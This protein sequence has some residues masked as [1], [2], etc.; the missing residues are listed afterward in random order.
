MERDTTT[1]NNITCSVP[2]DSDRNVRFRIETIQQT[3]SRIYG[4][5]FHHFH[6]VRL[7]FSLTCVPSPLLNRHANENCN[8]CLILCK[9]SPKH[10]CIYRVL[11]IKPF[12]SNNLSL[13]VEHDFNELPKST[14]IVVHCCL[15]VSKS[16]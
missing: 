13:L 4:R 8:N 1:T 7:D 11:S 14:G 2:D 12:T 5:T 3:Y 16:L 10:A 9:N 15:S 6:S